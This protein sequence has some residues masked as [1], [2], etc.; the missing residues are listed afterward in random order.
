MR[1]SYSEQ[2]KCLKK[3]HI[4]YGL[5]MESMQNYQSKNKDGH[6]IQKKD[7]RIH[8]RRKYTSEKEESFPQIFQAIEK[9]KEHKFLMREDIKYEIIKSVNELKREIVN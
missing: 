8:S 1:L 5:S 7:R 6:K 3:D 4:K 9:L 2:L